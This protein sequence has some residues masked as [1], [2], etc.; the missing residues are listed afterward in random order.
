MN[1]KEIIDEERWEDIPTIVTARAAYN[2][3]L[4]RIEDALLSPCIWTQDPIDDKY[5]TECGHGWTMHDMYDRPTDIFTYCPYC[6]RRIKEA[7]I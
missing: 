5:D 2:D 3:S 4:S 7:Q 6:G 1:I